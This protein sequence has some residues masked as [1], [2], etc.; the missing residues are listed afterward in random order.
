M[1]FHKQRT[2]INTEN[3]CKFTAGQHTTEA[4]LERC[5]I[6]ILPDFSFIG[7]LH[8]FCTLLM[9][10]N[11][12]FPLICSSIGTVWNGFWPHN[13]AVKIYLGV[14]DSSVPRDKNLNFTLFLN[15]NHLSFHRYCESWV[16]L[17]PVPINPVL[18]EMQQAGDF[19]GARPAVF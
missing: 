7:I 19:N 3:A 4:F 2:V 17:F 18:R 16:Y 13:V 14:K 10:G 1:I 15:V 12:C 9:T 11:C 5:F 8:L 6:S